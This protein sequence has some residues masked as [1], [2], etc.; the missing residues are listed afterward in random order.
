MGS[1]RESQKLK[2][3]LNNSWK[4]DLKA[5][6]PR[7]LSLLSVRD[8]AFQTYQRKK[9][10]TSVKVVFQRR[11]CRTITAVLSKP[12][13][14]QRTSTHFSPSEQVWKA[15]QQAWGSHWTFDYLTDTQTKRRWAPKASEFIK[16]QQSQL[17]FRPMKAN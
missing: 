7:N 1:N 9:W 3:S 5:T 13:R 4:C 6:K 12:S 15:G 14:G 2:V 17:R 11:E 10:N 8:D 16:V